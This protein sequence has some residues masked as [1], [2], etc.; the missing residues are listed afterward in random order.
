MASRN[1]RQLADVI[2]RILRPG[3]GVGTR[4]ALF[5]LSCLGPLATPT[6][7]AAQFLLVTGGRTQLTVRSP[8]FAGLDPR[9]DE[10]EATRMLWLF[11]PAVTT[12]IVAHTVAPGQ[13]FRLYTQARD[14]LS[15]DGLAEIELR[16]GAPPQDFIRNIRRATIIGRANIYFRAEA[17]ASTGNSLINGNDNHTVI[18]TWTTQ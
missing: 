14:V 1:Y 13:S 6:P 7:A 4:R 5:L 18:F 12:K 16:D 11:A 17:P 15:G 9:P 8:Q 3:R 2:R 10:D